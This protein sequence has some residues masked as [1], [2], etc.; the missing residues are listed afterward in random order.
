MRR[1]V[2]TLSESEG[3]RSSDKILRLRHRMTS[4]V[5]ILNLRFLTK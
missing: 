5:E 1:L 4:E 2:V 3:S